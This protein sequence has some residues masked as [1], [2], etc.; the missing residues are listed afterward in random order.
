MK[1]RGKTSER[2]GLDT[3]SSIR[4]AIERV[5]LTVG[6]QNS[7]DDVEPGT[8][9]ATIEDIEV[10][11]DRRG[12]LQTEETRSITVTVPTTAFDL[13]EKT[14]LY[15]KRLNMG[16][17]HPETF[18][19][20]GLYNGLGRKM[21]AR[22]YLLAYSKA[23]LQS[24]T[25]GTSGVSF[26]KILSTKD[27]EFLTNQAMFGVQKSVF[28]KNDRYADRYMKGVWLCF[29]ARTTSNERPTRHST[30]CGVSAPTVTSKPSS[31]TTCGIRSRPTTSSIEATSG[32]S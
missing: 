7:G 32:T 29:M 25:G 22:Y 19:A 3:Q 16:F 18:T 10:S 5:D 20:D 14:Q 6:N 9:R 4:D 23:Y 1:S 17:F 15:Q 11:V 28:G 21:A 30:R 26:D 2:Y 12:N 24:F 27:I 13:H 31:R 8:V